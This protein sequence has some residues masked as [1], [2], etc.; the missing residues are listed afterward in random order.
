MLIFHLLITDE[1][2]GDVLLL[3]S[4]IFDSSTEN[5]AWRSE[6]IVGIYEQKMSE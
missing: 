6:I 1:S 2:L 3:D 4:I 5:N